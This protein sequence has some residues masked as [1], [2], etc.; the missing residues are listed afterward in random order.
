MILKLV[1]VLAC[2]ATF[3]TAKIMIITADLN[4]IGLQENILEVSPKE[5]LGDY[6]RYSGGQRQNGIFMKFLPQQKVEV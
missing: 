5:S 6:R 4:D 3:S 2:V 1:F